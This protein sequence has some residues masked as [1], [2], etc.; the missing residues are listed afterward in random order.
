MASVIVLV[1]ER[2]DLSTADFARIRLAETVIGIAVALA[3]NRF[4]FPPR[5]Y[6]SVRRDLGATYRH[7]S[8]LF[9][10]IASACAGDL[11]DERSIRVARQEIRADL[12]AMDGLWDEA[13]SEHPPHEVLAPHWRALTEVETIEDTGSPPPFS[14]TLQILGVVNG[15]SVVAAHLI[16]IGETTDP[17]SERPPPLDGHHA[18]DAVPGIAPR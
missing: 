14:V 5:A 3:V 2:T 6:R 13:M 4:L 1:P 10:L 7:L 9:G 15:M 17:R 16:D 18:L 11:V 12:R 8:D